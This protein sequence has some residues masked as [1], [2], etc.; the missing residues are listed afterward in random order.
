MVPHGP[1]KR[2]EFFHKGRV[3]G[4]DD[5]Q[6][7][8]IDPGPFNLEN[9]PHDILG[10]ADPVQQSNDPLHLFFEQ[11]NIIVA[12]EEKEK[13]AAAWDF[14]QDPQHDL[15]ASPAFS[16]PPLLKADSTTRLPGES[17]VQFRAPDSSASDTFHNGRAWK[18]I[19]LPI[20]SAAAGSLP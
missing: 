11:G 19:A 6:E 7:H 14:C 12:L 1:P 10:A 16:Q 5:A 8:T 18:T 9:Q 4:L 20:P 15:P 3:A 2:P 13:R 17:A